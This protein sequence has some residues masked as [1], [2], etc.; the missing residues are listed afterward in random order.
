MLMYKIFL[1][2]TASL[3]FTSLGSVMSRYLCKYVGNSLTTLHAITYTSHDNMCPY[4]YLEY[5]N[6]GIWG[7]KIEGKTLLL[8]K[9]IYV[10]IDS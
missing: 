9:C 6:V 5:T 4:Y 10:P 2:H 3:S 7:C 8:G 1:I